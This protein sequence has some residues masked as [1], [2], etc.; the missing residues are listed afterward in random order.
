MEIN[1][2]V[3]NSGDKSQREAEVEGEASSLSSNVL[4]NH[5]GE[6]TL[7]LN[8]DGLSWE[9]LDSSDNCGSTCLG[10]EFVPKIT[11]K[12]TTELQFSDIYAV[13]LIHGGMIQESIST[14]ARECF[15][16]TDSHDSEMNHFI[17]HSFQKSM[18][19][20]CLWVLAVYTFGHKD[21]QTCQMWMNK[22]NDSLNKEFGRPK[23]L[24]VFVHP[25]SGKANG[26]RTWETVA[27]IFSRAK[28]NTKV[29]VTQ[30][31][32]HA[33]DVM[34]STTNEELNS[35]DGAVAVGGD[36]FFNEILNGYLRSRHKAPF[37]PAPSDFLDA[38]GNDG[39]SLVHDPAGAGS[40]THN[41]ESYPLLP[42]LA[43]NELGFSHLGTNNSSRSID[44]EIEY[45]LP[46]QRFRFG[47]IPAG[48]TDAIVICT[49]GARDPIT[50]ALHIVLG[51]RVCLDV[52]QVVR[53]KTTSSSK[54]EPCVRYA[55]SFAGYGFYGD[56]IAESEKYR[57][58]G[59]KRYDYAGTKV[60]LKHRSYE[61]EVAYLE[62]ESDKNNSIPDASRMFDKVRSLKRKKSERIIC[63]VNCNVCNTKPVYSSAR[64][65]PA[66]PYMR[67]QETRWLKSKGQFLSVGAAIMSNR[68][69]RAPDG[70]VADAHLSDGFLHLLL[71]KD[72]PH[73]LYLW[74]LTQLARKGGNPLNFDF[75]EHHKTPAFT[76]TSFGKESVWN[77]DGELFE[78][79]KLSAQVFRGLVCLFASGP[80][81]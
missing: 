40:G 30:R 24:L 12:T 39:S 28:I 51:K 77:L 18:S 37:P 61:A 10:I 75:V 31:A 49:T 35:Y 45:P 52:A 25:M 68:N 74:H 29:V 78:A 65:S 71:I 34:T 20:P 21:L 48:S 13:E 4:L 33:F 80:E 36:G 67:P 5:T 32:G 69:E 50:S 41:E 70:L 58:M 23:N 2:G 15:F 22:I 6:V 46:N 55:A 3:C 56:V 81:V 59:P 63:R 9:A 79:H 54:V 53:W 14:S 47:I 19:Q 27:P 26:L 16:G 44:Q 57:W 17:V 43:H 42:S 8:S 1:G 76:F 64:S 7:T 62:V 66:T 72:C 11:T 38:L 73:A 60:F